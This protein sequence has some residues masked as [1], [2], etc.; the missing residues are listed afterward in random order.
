MKTVRLVIHV[1]SEA[2]ATALC[3][4]LRQW[5]CTRASRN[6]WHVH[7]TVPSKDVMKAVNALN[8][9]AIVKEAK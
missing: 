5:S 8:I 7:T 6:W 9:R 1:Q 2:D 3:N 4:M